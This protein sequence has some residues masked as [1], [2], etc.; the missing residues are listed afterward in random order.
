MDD[1]KIQA[2]M[3]DAALSFARPDA[4]E[5]IARMLIDVALEHES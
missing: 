3:H 4:A 2:S 1:P 5:K